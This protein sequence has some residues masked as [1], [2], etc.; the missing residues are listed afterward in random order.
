MLA[1]ILQPQDRLVDV[2]LHEL[3]SELVTLFLRSIGINKTQLSRKAT[4]SG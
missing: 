3:S 4:I 1:F 2:S